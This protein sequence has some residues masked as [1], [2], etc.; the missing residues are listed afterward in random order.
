M[1]YKLPFNIQAYSYTSYIIFLQGEDGLNDTKPKHVANFFVT[2]K[3]PP[4]YNRCVTTVL[5]VYFN[6]LLIR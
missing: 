2:I 6:S 1:S 3:Y 5:T 4:Q